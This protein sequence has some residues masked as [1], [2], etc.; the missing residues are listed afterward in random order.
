HGSPGSGP[1]WHRYARQSTRR[2]RALHIH[3]GRIRKSGI[4]CAEQQ[5]LGRVP[6]FSSA[7]EHAPERRLDRCT[8]IGGVCLLQKAERYTNTVP[9][10]GERGGG[11]PDSNRREGAIR[12][13][14]SV[15]SL[16]S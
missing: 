10:P 5:R 6:V 4:F 15:S 8:Y 14:R 3:A 1:S 2:G 7:G 12:G 9:P 11:A 13:E 16:A